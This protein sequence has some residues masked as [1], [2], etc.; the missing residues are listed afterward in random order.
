MQTAA[1]L[2]QAAF[3]NNI[4]IN[5]KVGYGEFPA[6]NGQPQQSLP[7]QNTSEGGPWGSFL[8]YTTLRQDLINTASSADDNAS[9]ASLPNSSSLQ[10]QSSF[11]VANAQLKVFGVA[12][13]GA[14]DGGVGM[15]I[16]FTGNVLIAG[17]LHEI[18]H[19]MG[20]VAGSSLDLFRFNE[21]HSGNRVFGGG[22]SLRRLHTFRP[23]ARRTSRTL[24]KVRT[25]A[26]FSTAAF[27]DRTI[28]STKSSVTSPL[29][30]PPISRSWMS[31]D[32]TERRLRSLIWWWRAS[33]RTRR[34]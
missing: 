31:S 15:G 10:G 32:F 11:F 4:T 28:P 21:D 5:I 7:N 26:T 16:N 29:S 3:D 2:L 8:S 34:A 33:H 17:A 6:F 9:V 19:A 27:R 13:S 30:L 18:T 24:A 20:R 1:N 25:L 12:T 14:S 23:V 22:R